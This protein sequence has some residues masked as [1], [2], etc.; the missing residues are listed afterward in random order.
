MNFS[1][2]MRYRVGVVSLARANGGIFLENNLK[3]C[4]VSKPLE[5]RLILACLRTQSRQDEKEKISELSWLEVNTVLEAALKHLRNRLHV[6]V[7]QSFAKTAELVR[8]LRRFE[9]TDIPALA[10][11]GPALALQVH[12]DPSS[13][14]EA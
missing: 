11:S 1:P 3:P 6:N 12:G 4:L 13:Y 10:L 14:K 8:I 7:A 2:S 5:P 9:Q